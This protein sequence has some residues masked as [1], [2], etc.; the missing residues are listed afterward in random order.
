MREKKKPS[1]KGEGTWMRSTRGPTASMWETRPEGRAIR[2][3]K[4]NKE[5]ERR[6][7]ARWWTV[8]RGETSL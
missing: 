6:E 8:S 4:E 2:G 7:E 3:E 1:L 5:N